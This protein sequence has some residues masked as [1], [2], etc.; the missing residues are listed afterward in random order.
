M[1]KLL[2]AAVAV[3]AIA[4]TPAMAA[5]TA[6]DYEFKGSVTEVCSTTTAT[7]S[8]FTIA[9]D[10][11]FAKQTLSDS[12]AYCNGA[13]T[14]ASYV[15]THLTNDD[16]GISAPSGFTTTVPI[17]AEVKAGTATVVAGGSTVGAFNGLTVSATGDGVASGTK[18]MAGAYSGKIT[19]TLTPGA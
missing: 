12:T 9:L 15:V 4:A 19:V 13:T 5:G 2:L 3:S 18:V 16:T 1:K 8:G 14:T 7:K 17:T 6:T 10:G 11:T